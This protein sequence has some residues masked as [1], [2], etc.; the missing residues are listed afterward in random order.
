MYSVLLSLDIIFAVLITLLVLM[1]RSEGGALGAMGGGTG[2]NLFTGRQAG[3]FLTKATAW[4]FVLFVVTNIV[5]VV[6]AKNMS[7]PEKVSILPV[8]TEQSAEK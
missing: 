2:A 8:Q 7:A 1:Q 4:I 6:M 3:N 5:L